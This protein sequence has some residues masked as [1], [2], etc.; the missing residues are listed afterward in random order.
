[1]KE[2]IIIGLIVLAIVCGIIYFFTSTTF[3]LTVVLLLLIILA[4][5]SLVTS[6]TDWV[7]R[8]SAYATF[9]L[10]G[11][12]EKTGDEKEAVK[13]LYADKRHRK[14]MWFALRQFVYW[15]FL[16]FFFI[17]LGSKGIYPQLTISY[18]LILLLQI[19]WSFKNAKQGKAVVNGQT[20]AIQTTY[21]S[22]NEIYL[23]LKSKSKWWKPIWTKIFNF[24]EL[25]ILVLALGQVLNIFKVDLF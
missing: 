12:K 20:T 24:A 14:L 22:E 13:A 7:Y 4:V 2:N 19:T 9:L 15:S 23:E 5:R 17:L 21:A 6:K 11:L 18:V 1:M 10:Q 8:E 25:C 3:G 16:A